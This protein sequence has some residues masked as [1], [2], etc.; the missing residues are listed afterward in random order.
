MC[1]KYSRIGYIDTVVVQFMKQLGIG[2]QF[3]FKWCNKISFYSHTLDLWSFTLDNITSI[4]MM[5][6]MYGLDE[7]HV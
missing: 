5:H 1:L 7:T 6:I 2:N 3:F 4:M